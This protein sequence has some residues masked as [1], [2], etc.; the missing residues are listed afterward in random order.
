MKWLKAVAGLVVLGGFAYGVWYIREKRIEVPFIG[1]VEKPVELRDGLEV[2]LVLLTP[3]ESGGS[4]EGKEVKLVAAENVKVGGK[5]VIAQGAIA[6]GKVTKSRSGTL[7]GAITNMPARLEVELDQIKAV[8]GKPIK[9]RTH[10]IGE[11]FEFTQ[12]NTKPEEKSSTV[13]LVRD[14]KARDFV[15]SL[16]RQIATG[17]ELNPDD[18]QKADEQL[19]DLAGR[20]GFENT[21]KFLRGSKGAK[22]SDIPGL[23]ESVQKGDLQGLTGVD[24]L[25]AIKAAGE[26]LDVG[27]SIDRSLRNMFKGS[28]ITAR[29]G[30]AVPAYVAEDIAIKP[31]KEGN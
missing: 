15:A 26:I 12:A 1:E 31:R 17:K 6:T 14:E 27:S 28:N 2:P 13:D 3:L 21:E 18:K 11:P 30:T 4:E 19:K 10:A 24:A 5:V 7:V 9:L 22:K 29:V 20:Y 23:L 8:D 25:L 16:A